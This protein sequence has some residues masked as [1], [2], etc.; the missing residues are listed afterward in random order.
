[1]GVLLPNDI[2]L[3]LQQNGFEPNKKTVYEIVA[4]FDVAETGGISFRDFMTAM[5]TK[6]IQNESRKEI[7]SIFKKYDKGDWSSG[8][9]PVLGTGGP[10]FNS[11]IA[12]FFILSF[13][14]LLLLSKFFQQSFPTTPSFPT[15]PTP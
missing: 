4:E 14:P 12:P 2:K 10:G 3:F 5:S 15:S 13:Y 7:A 9:I 1:M 6:P 8:M 11:R